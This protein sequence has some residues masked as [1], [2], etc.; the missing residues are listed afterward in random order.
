M[1]LLDKFI[2]FIFSIAILIIAITVVMICFG[3]ISADKIYNI[4]DQYVFDESVIKVSFIIA[5]VVILAA[6][7][8]TIFSSSFKKKDKSPILVENEH[9]KVEISQDTI[10]NTVRNVAYSFPAVKDVQAKMFKKNKG[11]KI[12]A[13]ISVLANTN[14][15][16]LTNEL[17]AK[18]KEVIYETTAIKTLSINVKVKNIYD[19]NKKANKTEV[20]NKPE[21]KTV[22][23]E[24]KK[25][26]EKVNVPEVK[27]VVAPVENVED[28]SNEQSG[29]V[30]E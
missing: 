23:E 8:T 28:K 15:R 5:I 27:E 1:K 3:Y 25:V 26:E 30:N 21:V 6:L 2:S 11:V 13:A 7:K 20:Q 24:V 17:Q 9:G 29:E 19:K 14:I 22:K 4:I 10:D 12:Y 18:I 16:E